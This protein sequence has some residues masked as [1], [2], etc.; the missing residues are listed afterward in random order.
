MAAL[1]CHHLR[2][3]MHLAERRAIPVRLHKDSRCANVPIM[4]YAT[5]GTVL[6]DADGVLHDYGGLQRSGLRDQLQ[7]HA[8]LREYCAGG[9]SPGLWCKL[10]R[11]AAMLAPEREK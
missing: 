11:A 5:V 1:V 8:L 9:G 2:I 4:T 6:F 7:W 10:W 3:V